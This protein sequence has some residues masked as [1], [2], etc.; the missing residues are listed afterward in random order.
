MPRQTATDDGEP[1]PSFPSNVLW[2]VVVLGLATSMLFFDPAQKDAFRFP[3]ILI[4]RTLMILVAA[5]L[6]SGWILRGRR[7]INLN[8]LQ[9]IRVY[10]LA[11]VT[12]TAIA[13]LLSSNVQLSADTLFWV[14]GMVIL[15]ASSVLATRF[16][17]QEAVLFPLIAALFVAAQIAIQWTGKSLLFNATFS[18]RPVGF[19]GNPN[20]AAALLVAPG[21]AAVA[22]AFA[23]RSLRPV[24]AAIAGF[25]CAAVF[26]TQS[27][28][29]VLSLLVGLLTIGLGAVRKRVLLLLTGLM[30]VGSIFFLWEPLLKPF[31]HRYREILNSG[32]E[33]SL[34]TMSSYRLRIFL[35]AAEMFQASPFHGVGP[36][37]FSWN[38][39]PY[40]VRVEEGR[41]QSLLQ[42]TD[43]G[44]DHEMRRTLGEHAHNEHLQILAETGFPGYALFLAAIFT[45]GRLSFSRVVTESIP[46]RVEERAVF[47][48]ILSI[49]LSVAVFVLCIAQFPLRLADASL[50]IIYLAAVCFSWKSS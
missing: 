36:G 44:S 14:V 9:P 45:L 26:M 50:M 28:T 2:P 21:L 13:T 33:G 29:A 46:A 49:G 4:V 39:F 30:V 22:G 31:E 17:G 12:W 20:D 11:V 42:V 1:D 41:F 27:V 32:R 8:P 43:P 10:L 6:S 23:F 48:R 34:E 3:K 7:W 25:L 38:F 15:F 35:T 24:Y 16:R 18:G 37:T 19:Q 5:I 40:R 47:S